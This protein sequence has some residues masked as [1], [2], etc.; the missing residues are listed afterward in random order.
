MV[1]FTRLSSCDKLSFGPLVKLVSW[2]LIFQKVCLVKDH[3]LY[4]IVPFWIVSLTH[5]EKKHNKSKKNIEFVIENARE[6]V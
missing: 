4:C 5:R 1:F 6:N 2:R 3:H